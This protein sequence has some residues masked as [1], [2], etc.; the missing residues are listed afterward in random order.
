MSTTSNNSILDNINENTSNIAKSVEQQVKSI[1]DQANTLQQN[2]TGKLNEFSNTTNAAVSGTTS[3]S[4]ADSNGII[5]KFGFFILV[6]ICFLIAL[7]LGIRLISYFMSPSTTVYI[8]NGL[9]DGT[10]KK[11]ISQNPNENP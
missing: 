3:S 1:G 8:I 4:F 2:V 11:V 5:A 6:I 9:I 10:S 7:N